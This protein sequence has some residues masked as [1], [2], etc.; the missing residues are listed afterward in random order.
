M[1]ANM[2]MKIREQSR[3]LEV[4]EVMK[5]EYAMLWLGKEKYQE[6]KGYHDGEMLVFA[7]RW[8]SEQEGMRCLDEVMQQD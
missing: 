7:E 3:S 1:L 5:S 6:E 8:L 2:E 4:L